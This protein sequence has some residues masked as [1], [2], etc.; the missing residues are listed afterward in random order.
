MVAL[1]NIGNVYLSNMSFPLS[2]LN[3][4]AYQIVALCDPKVKCLFTQATNTE[5]RLW[6]LE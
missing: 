5:V 4:T 6:P 2:I 1:G 3:T